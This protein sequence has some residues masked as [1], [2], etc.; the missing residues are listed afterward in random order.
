M[1]SNVNRPGL[2]SGSLWRYIRASM[3]IAGAL[4]PMI[5]PTDGH[6][7]VDG[8]YVNNVPGILFSLVF[9]RLLSFVLF[10]PLSSS[11]ETFQI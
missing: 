6:L 2:I 5:D 9:L 7:L 10:S 11:L 3:S 1:N 8:C 4:P